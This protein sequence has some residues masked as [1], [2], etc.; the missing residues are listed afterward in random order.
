MH[1][2]SVSYACKSWIVTFLMRSKCALSKAPLRYIF[3]SLTFFF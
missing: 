1:L 2:P 3:S